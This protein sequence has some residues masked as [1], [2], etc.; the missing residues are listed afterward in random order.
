MDLNDLPIYDHH[1]HPLLHAEATQ[2]PARFRRW[3]TESTDAT[4]HAEHVEHTLLFQSTLRALAGMLDCAPTLDAVLAAR[5]EREYTEWTRTLFE[6]ARI[7][8]VLCDYGYGDASALTHEEMQATLPCPVAPILRLESLAEDLIRKH[9]MFDQMMAAFVETIGSARDAG[10]VA[11]K[12]IVAYRSGLDV[13]PVSRDAAVT[14]FVDLSEKVAR[15]EPIRLDRKPLCDYLLTVALAQAADQDLPVQFHTGFGDSDADLRDAS[16]LHL[17]WVIEEYPEV[18]LVLLHA[19]WPYYHELAHLAAIYPNVWLDISLAIPFATTGIPA[20]L[21]D[22]L[23][24][25]PFSKVLYATDAFTMPEIY[26]VAA[27][28]GRWGLE[29]VLDD[30]VGEGFISEQQAMDAAEAILAGNARAL[31]NLRQS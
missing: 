29:Q 25:A 22:V 13:G 23:G 12:S 11:L 1:A 18:P 24:M 15:G 4:V 28:W 26:W 31:Y 14:A 8:T 27:R 17:R 30:F 5:A 2:T 19:G 7:E 3:F 20:M 9:E 21:R 6:D 16:P 10:Y